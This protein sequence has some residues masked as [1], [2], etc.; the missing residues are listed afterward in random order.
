MK[1]KEIATALGLSVALSMTATGCA[2]QDEVNSLN[3]QV[4]EL[5][6]QV[7]ELQSEVDTEQAKSDN[8]E[9]Q[10]ESLTAQIEE[11]QSEIESLNEELTVD[12]EMIADAD[13]FADNASINVTK[14]SQ[15]DTAV[16][17]KVNESEEYKIANLDMN[18]ECYVVSVFSDV[19]NEDATWSAI[20]SLVTT[21]SDKNKTYQMISDV[22]RSDERT[23][24][25]KIDFMLRNADTITVDDQTIKADEL[26]ENQ[27]IRIVYAR[28]SLLSN[29][30]VTEQQKTSAEKSSTPQQSAP[31]QGS[32]TD[33][34]IP[35]ADYSWWDN[36]P[37]TTPGC[38]S[39]TGMNIQFH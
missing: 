27:E 28:T 22:K 3:A 31:Q 26:G 6:A 17:S 32:S 2:S 19:N 23:K 24:N 4:S 37:S 39:M 36:T 34:R 7:T 18:T 29:S 9:K 10:N 14:Y 30:K 13:E 8:V 21:D 11:L 20:A 35:D 25:S 5:Q 16:Y 38:P 12:G 33:G 15:K 1:K